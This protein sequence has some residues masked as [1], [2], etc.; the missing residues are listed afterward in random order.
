MEIGHKLKQMRVRQN[1]TLEELASRC[2][3]TKGFLS[4]VERNLTS[5]S[6]VTLNDILEALGSSLGEFFGEEKQEKIVFHKNDFFVDEKDDYIVNWIVPN[7]Q[8]NEMEPILIE[9]PPKSSSFV[10]NP[11]N[12]E[13]FGYVL[14]GIV[15]LDIGG[16]ASTVRK[17]ETFYLKGREDHSISNKATKTAKVLWISTPP[18]F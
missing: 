5:P 9:I 16:K 17:G 12:G 2:E 4:Q 18:I 8:K 1:L 7:S 14:D 10:V 15:T 13:E 3:L 11:H 6:I